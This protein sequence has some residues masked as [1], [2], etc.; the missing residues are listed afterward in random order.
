MH[1]SPRFH[2]RNFGESP[3]LHL[4]LLFDVV[5][6]MPAASTAIHTREIEYVQDTLSI[7]SEPGMGGAQLSR[8]SGLEFV[9]RRSRGRNPC[10][11]CDQQPRN[12]ILPANL[13]SNF[14]TCTTLER[15]GGEER[16]EVNLPHHSVCNQTSLYNSPARVTKSRTVLE[17]SICVGGR[18]ITNLV[19]LWGSDIERNAHAPRPGERNGL[20]LLDILRLSGIKGPW[21]GRTQRLRMR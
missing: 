10:N 21:C 4:C 14:R 5:S 12:S 7:Y 19:E 17:I 3:K 18:L 15:F 2:A 9:E 1:L 8:K 13:D 20:G 16:E 6:F 11:V